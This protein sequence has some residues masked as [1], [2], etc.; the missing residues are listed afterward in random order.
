MKLDATTV[1]ALIVASLLGALARDLVP[2]ARADSQ[3]FDRNLAERIVRAQESQAR[4]S[5]DLVRAVREC[6][7]R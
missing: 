2:A 3:A 7:R 4:A 5:E 1:I 6:G